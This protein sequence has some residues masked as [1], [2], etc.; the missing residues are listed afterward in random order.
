MET[1]LVQADEMSVLLYTAR[2]QGAPITISLFKY[3][4]KLH[5]YANLCKLVEIVLI[6]A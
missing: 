3:E 2:E 5:K 4:W 1:D 6:Y